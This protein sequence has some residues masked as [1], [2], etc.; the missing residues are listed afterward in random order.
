MV[1]TCDTYKKA[2]Y[3]TLQDAKTAKLQLLVQSVERAKTDEGYRNE[4]LKAL[5]LV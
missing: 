2:L 5:E 1:A 4:L 3:A